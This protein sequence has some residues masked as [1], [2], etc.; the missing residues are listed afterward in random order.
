MNTRL[1]A[2]AAMGLWLMSVMAVEGKEKEWGGFYGKLSAGYGSPDVV[3]ENL[4]PFIDLNKLEV[5]YISTF[6]EFILSHF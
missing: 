2:L 5:T 1:K 6:E 4:A 3:K